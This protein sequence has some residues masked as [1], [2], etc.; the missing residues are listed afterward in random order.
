MMSKTVYMHKNLTVGLTY[1]TEINEVGEATRHLAIPTEG[2]TSEIAMFRLLPRPW[3]PFGTNIVAR[4]SLQ[5][6]QA[7]G[8]SSTIA[9]ICTAF[10]KVVNQAGHLCYTER[11]VSRGAYFA[12]LN[13][14]AVLDKTA[15]LKIPIMHLSIRTHPTPR[16]ISA[17]AGTLIITPR[18]I[19]IELT[20]K[21][22]STLVLSNFLRRG[23]LFQIVI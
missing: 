4:Q 5:E 23:N 2:I 12:S 1:F 22:D 7:L 9:D 19:T 10:I 11:G 3:L 6:L 17:K 18:G 13:D 15:D 14:I 16:N 21:Q 20:K 8:P